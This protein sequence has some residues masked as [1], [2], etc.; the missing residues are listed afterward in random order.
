MSSR[1]IIRLGVLVLLGSGLLWAGDPWKEK[2]WMEWSQKDVDKVLQ[3]SPWAQGYLKAKE[4][5]PEFDPSLSAEQ[6]ER[7]RSTQVTDAYFTVVWESARTVKEAEA[8]LS[9][10]QTTGPEEGD[11][12]DLAIPADHVVWVSGYVYEGRYLTDLNDF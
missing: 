7:Q 2:P 11:D 6:R 12:W 8:R 4:S 9:Q 1:Q 10:L 3:D 5:Q